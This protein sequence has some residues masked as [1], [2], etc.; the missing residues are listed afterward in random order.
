MNIHEIKVNLPKQLKKAHESLTNLHKSLTNLPHV[1]NTEQKTDLQG[2]FLYF[3]EDH[4]SRNPILLTKVER[5]APKRSPLF[6]K[7]NAIVAEWYVNPTVHLTKHY[8][9]QKKDLINRHRNRQS[10][11]LWHEIN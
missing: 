6:Q 8:A 1:R 10:P 11:S 2:N 7:Q 4:R 5:P 9:L 3:C